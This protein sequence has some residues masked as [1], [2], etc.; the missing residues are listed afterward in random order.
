MKAVIRGKFVTE[1]TYI[2]KEE[3]FQANNLTFQFKTL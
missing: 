3:R 1:N 2:I